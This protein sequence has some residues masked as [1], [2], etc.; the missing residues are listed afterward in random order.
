MLHQT[1]GI[2]ISGEDINDMLSEI[3][4]KINEITNLILY[5]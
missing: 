4:V 3:A 2:M 1:F 5:F